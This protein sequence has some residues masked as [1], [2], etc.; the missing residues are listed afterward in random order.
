[1]V[2]DCVK[3]LEEVESRI[4]SVVFVAKDA[5][6]AEMSDATV[7]VGTTTLTRELD[8]KAIETNPGVQTFVFTFPS[9][10]R[11]AQKAI[12]KEGE[13]A[14][15]VTVTLA[16]SAVSPTRSAASPSPSPSRASS[17]MFD[18]D[19]RPAAFAVGG[20]GVLGLAVGGIFGLKAIGAKSDAN[21]TNDFCDPQ[22]LADA[23]SA[24]TVSTIGF[25]AGAA[26]IA[27]GAALFFLGPKRTEPRTVGVA[28]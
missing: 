5:S 2:K 19:T 1:M 22:H 3:W 17:A 16:A 7:S 13:K 21:C 26:L 11:I 9:G 10:Q 24:A 15:R 25:I 28:R 20:A 8:G 6:G 4:P 23:R 18:F 27:G 12:V 14:Q